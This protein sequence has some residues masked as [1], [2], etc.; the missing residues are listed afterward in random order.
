MPVPPPLESR[1][2][3]IFDHAHTGD[4]RKRHVTL[5]RIDMQAE[6]KPLEEQV[7]VITG[8]SSGIGLTT[9]RMA[10]DR[11]ATLVVA[12]RSE[13][14]LRELTETIRA[15]GGNAEYVVADV[16]DR[17]DVRE[18]ARVAEERFGGFD[19]WVNGAAVSIY[20]RLEDVPVEEMREQFDVN[21]WGLLYGSLEAADRLRERGGV[22]INIGSIVSDRAIVL[23]GSYSASKHAVK[24]FTDTLRTELESDDAPVSV[25]LV[26]PSG[27]DTPFAEHAKNHMDEAATLPAPVYAPETVAR[28]I[29][30]AAEQPER[31]VTVGAGGKNVTV[32]ERTASK[33]VDRF[34]ESVFF[35]QQRTGEPPRP[36]AE[37]GLEEP[38]GDL[39]ERG[40]YDGHVAESSLYTAFRQRREVPRTIAVGLGVAATAAYAGYRTLRHG[41]DSVDSSRSDEDRPEF[42][43]ARR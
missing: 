35:R 22:I 10:A 19:T 34:M 14:A 43:H 42:E 4:E 13:D 27:T 24:G 21:V 20:G 39:T 30:H 1:S 32:L 28:A 5:L 15:D 33:L 9:A 31:E 38:V 23:Q 8:A 18:I 36:D 7:I 37:N 11:G 2:Y 3:A 25:T 12:A 16:R 26:K 40:G 41:D 6:L 29:L 17:D